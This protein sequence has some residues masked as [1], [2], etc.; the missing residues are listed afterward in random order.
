MIEPITDAPSFWYCCLGVPER[1]VQRQTAEALALTLY[2]GVPRPVWDLFWL[3]TAHPGEVYREAFR[4]LYHL[5]IGTMEVDGSPIEAVVVVEG[6][7]GWWLALSLFIL[8]PS[9]ACVGGCR[10][11]TLPSP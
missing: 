1:T 5:E 8:S 2:L 6:F 3:V 7:A 10:Q 9:G 4:V 11:T